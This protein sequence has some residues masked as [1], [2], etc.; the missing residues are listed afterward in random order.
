M[1]KNKFIIHTDGGARGNPGPA[2]LGAVIEAADKSL[3]KEYGEYLGQTTNNIAEYQAVVFA[4]KKLKQLMGGEK[5]GKANVEIFADSELLVKQVNGKYKVL[6]A[7]IQKLFLEVWNLRLDFGKVTF[8]HIAR[9]KN[10]RADGM[11]NRVLDKEMYG[12]L[13]F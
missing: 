8:K 5:A 13:N 7:G 9:E 4:L 10:R 11:V 12:R 3:T 2:A 1:V 6:D